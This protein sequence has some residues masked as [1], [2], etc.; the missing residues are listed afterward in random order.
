MDLEEIED[1]IHQYCQLW[2]VYA[3]TSVELKRKSKLSWESAVAACKVY[4]LYI[5]DVL[6]QVDKIMK[7]LAM[8][9]ELRIIKN[10]GHFPVPEITPQG[11]KI[12]NT[13]DFDKVL[14][15]VDREVVE[16]L[17]A[18]RESEHNYKKEKVEAR[19]KEQQVIL[20]RQTNRSDFTF[21][22]INSS[23][24]IRNNNTVPQTRTNQQTETAVHFDPN[25]IHHYYPMTDLTSCSDQYE[26][27]ANDSI[28]QGADSASRDQFTTNTTGVTGHNERWRYNNG[29][30]TATH[31]GHQ[32]RMTRPS[33]HNSSHNN[34]PNSS[35][36]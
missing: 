25:T 1:K 3:E 6:Q 16:M 9:K 26:P 15:A 7:L 5:S 2:K 18:V 4:G 11:M 17:T 21:P 24:P 34:S 23:T 10:R 19:N 22:T 35:H 14:E 33:S 27:P 8:E 32:T 20:A 13:R 31:T 28:I 30:N 29:T 36:N 12:E